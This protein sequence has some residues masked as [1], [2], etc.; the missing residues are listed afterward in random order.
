M[1]QAPG[2]PAIPDSS[3]DGGLGPNR[4]APLSVHSARSENSA[5]RRLTADRAFEEWKLR[6]A[7]EL[8]E[9]EEQYR[10]ALQEELALAD[11]RSE[12]V[13]EPPMDGF[14]TTGHEKQSAA[15]AE[16]KVVL[17][18]L[19]E[20]ADERETLERI[21]KA[22]YGQVVAA[23]EA[24]L[25]Q[26]SAKLKIVAPKE[27]DGEFD[28]VK[29]ET[30]IKSARGYL[31][32]IGIADRDVLDESLDS[33][34]LHT[35]RMLFSAKET[36]GF[37]PQAWFNARHEREPFTNLA[38]VFDAVRAYWTDDQAAEIAYDKYRGARQGTLRAR[39][40]GAL[41]EVL[42]NGCFD[43]TI[44][45][46]DRIATFD[47]GLNANYREF[48]KTQV[49]LLS[50]MGNAPTTLEGV[51]KLA[52][53]AD[54]LVSFSASLKKSSSSSSSLPSIASKKSALTP[55]SSSSPTLSSSSNSSAS[56]GPE[57]WVSQA[58]AW[59]ASFPEAE[60]SS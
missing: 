7:L 22:K 3:D 24:R 8:A 54:G 21:L 53:V 20:L 2:L 14:K 46:A 50:Q 23:P 57:H 41:V 31:N 12:A 35:I 10:M 16:H 32:G 19:K 58:T 59:Q 60:K 47:R 11:I 28:H 42:A 29:R 9:E 39:E 44:D 6:R 4:Y 5:A 25:A 43:R 45:D 40:F 38:Q 18:R 27:W 17:R 56:K 52:A 37:S 13:Q 34:P 55:S 33:L 48:L 1:S 49:A 51:V 15:E 30:W 26:V 36:T